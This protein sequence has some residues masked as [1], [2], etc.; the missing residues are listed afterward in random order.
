MLDRLGS[1]WAAPCVSGGLFWLVDPVSRSQGPPQSIADTLGVPSPVDAA[2]TRCN[3]H[4]TVYIIKVR[5][6]TGLS[7]R[8]RLSVED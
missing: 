3:C 2:F 1:S 8:K 5:E 7:S 6:E 4:G